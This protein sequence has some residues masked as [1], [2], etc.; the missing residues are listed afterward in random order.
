MSEVSEREVEI[1]GEQGGTVTITG[2]KGEGH[3]PVRTLSHRFR[4]NYIRT[5]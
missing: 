2:R 1:G 3:D 4:T 5:S